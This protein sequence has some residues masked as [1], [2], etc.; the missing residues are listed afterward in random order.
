M[1]NSPTPKDT[2]ERSDRK[3]RRG[4][5]GNRRFVIYGYQVYNENGRYLGYGPV[6]DQHY[7]PEADINP[8][9][10]NEYWGYGGGGGGGY[11]GGRLW[12]EKRSW[13]W[14]GDYGGRG[15]HGGRRGNGGR[16]GRW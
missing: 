12:W 2:H 1:E 10:Y 16:G 4:R 13:R 14:R 5:R 6:Y 11:S 7:R 3:A 9:Q 8:R 15:G